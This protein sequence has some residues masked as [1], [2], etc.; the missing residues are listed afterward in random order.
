MIWVGPGACVDGTREFVEHSERGVAKVS[1]G[2]GI[3]PGSY[4]ARYGWSLGHIWVR[5]G[6]TAA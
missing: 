5:Y 4:G 6:G 2:L 3:Y 1:R